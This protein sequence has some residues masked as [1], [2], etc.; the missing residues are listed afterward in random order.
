MFDVEIVLWL[1][2]PVRATR[3]AGALHPFA[4]LSDDEEQPT[5]GERGIEFRRRA[6]RVSLLTADT[7]RSHA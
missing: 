2:A 1:A 5:G 4:S 7:P 6:A 3:L